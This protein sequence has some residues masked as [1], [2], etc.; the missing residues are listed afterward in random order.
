MPGG[1]YAG[2]RPVNPFAGRS[3][4]DL[5]RTALEDPQNVY[6]AVATANRR[7]ASPSFMRFLETWMPQQYAAYNTQQLQNPTAGGS[8]YQFLAGQLPTAMT[9]YRN[10]GPYAYNAALYQRPTRTLRY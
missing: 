10:T 1:M 8:F 6:D 4:S 7:S 5:Q 3:Y 9:D 2:Y